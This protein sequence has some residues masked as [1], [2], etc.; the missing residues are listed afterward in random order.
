MTGTEASVR[1]PDGLLIYATACLCP[2]M[3]QPCRRDSIHYSDTMRMVRTKPTTSFRG[4]GRHVWKMEMLLL[5]T[6]ELLK[7]GGH[8]FGLGGATWLSCGGGLAH[9]LLPAVAHWTA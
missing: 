3:S 5:C 7:P 8:A 6:V 1:P 9:S 2:N 4:L